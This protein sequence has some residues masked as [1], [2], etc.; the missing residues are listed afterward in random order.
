M[1]FDYFNCYYR[2][3]SIRSWFNNKWAHYEP[4][5]NLT[6]SQINVLSS[7]KLLRKKKSF[8]TFVHILCL[9]FIWKHIR[10]RYIIL[11]ANRIIKAD[12]FFRGLLS[13]VHM[14][15]QNNP[16]FHRAMTV[17]CLHDLYHTQACDKKTPKYGKAMWG[18]TLPSLFYCLSTHATCIYWVPFY[19]GIELGALRNAKKNKMW[20]S[21]DFILVERYQQS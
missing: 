20:M 18:K 10:K 1:C 13:R 17:L 15:I 3:Y 6:K 21:A 5:H 16:E 2:K 9:Y 12:D 19:K 11:E 8:R 4:S 14:N 7:T